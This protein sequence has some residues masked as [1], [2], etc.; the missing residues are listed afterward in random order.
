MKRTHRFRFSF[1]TAK[2]KIYVSA[3]SYADALQHMKTTG[4]K[5]NQY[6]GVVTEIKPRGGK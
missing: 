1:P 5:F 3:D 4:V 2:G 6:M